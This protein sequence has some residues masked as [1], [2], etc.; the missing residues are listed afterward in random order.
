MTT[1][2]FL[3]LNMHNTAK[4]N[5][6]VND[7]LLAAD[8]RIALCQ[9][10]SQQKCKIKNLHPQIRQYIGIH[11]RS[12]IRPRACILINTTKLRLLRLS[13]FC[14]RDLVAILVDTNYV[15]ASCYMPYEV[16][17]PPSHKLQQLVEFCEDKSINLL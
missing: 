12:N 15:I 6:E 3:Q 7:W 17:D 13:Q 9:E 5:T 10:P 16:S 4:V 1:L 2:N 14:D 8:N 11:P